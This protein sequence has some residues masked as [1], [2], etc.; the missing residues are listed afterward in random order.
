MLNLP[1]GDMNV[2]NLV[3]SL[4]GIQDMP[5]LQNK[6]ICGRIHQDTPLAVKDFPLLNYSETSQ[7]LHC[8]C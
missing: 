7:T 5:P 8:Q 4:L 3:D 2:R 1:A 6:G